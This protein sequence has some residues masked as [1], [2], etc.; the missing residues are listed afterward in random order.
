MKKTYEAP[1]IEK[2]AFNYRDQVVAASGV[3]AGD[4]GVIDRP[5]TGEQI[6]T[7]VAQSM[8]I[9]GCES[10]SCNSLFNFSA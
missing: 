6:A 8:G 1:S 9:P 2:I 5:S 10:I 3:F 7:R 4:N